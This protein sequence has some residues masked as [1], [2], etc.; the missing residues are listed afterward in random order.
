ML[1]TKGEILQI[2]GPPK[3]IKYKVKEAQ[4]TEDIIK[5]IINTHDFFRGDYDKFSGLF[6]GDS[7]YE[8]LEDIF[9][10]CRENL[11]YKVETG[12]YQTTKG[13]AVI[14][15]S[16]YN[17]C[18]HYSLFIG[19]I[20]D[21]LN[22]RHGKN[23]DW[24]YRFAG[25]ND[26]SE[27]LHHVFIVVNPGKNS[28]IW[29]D[30]CFANLDDRSSIP[31]AIDDIKVR[32]TKKHQKVKALGALE[33]I[34]LVELTD[35]LN[36]KDAI[37]ILDNITDTGGDY[38]QTVSPPAKRYLTDEE[39]NALDVSVSEKQSIRLGIEFQK[40][41][42]QYY[43]DI[44]EYFGRPVN[45][46]VLKN[47][48]FIYVLNG[49]RYELPPVTAYWG[50]PC[51]PPPEGLTVIYNRNIY[52]Y[53]IPEG[54][55]APII[56]NGKLVFDRLYF[57]GTNEE[58]TKKLMGE[59]GAFLMVIM[60]AAMGGLQLAYSSY[61]DAM[62]FE[63]ML[64]FRVRHNRNHENFLKAHNREPKTFVG[65]IIKAIGQGIESIGQGAVKIFGSVPRQAFRA[66][67]ASN[68]ANLAVYL[69]QAIN[70]D[71]NKIKKWWEKWGGD[72]DML[73]RS[74][75]AGKDEKP[76]YLGISQLKALEALSQNK[77]A[78]WDKLDI[79]ED[80]GAIGEAVSTATALTALPI[81]ASVVE[82]ISAFVKDDNTRRILQT[83]ARVMDRLGEGETPIDISKIAG[84]LDSN[85]FADINGNN[86]SNGQPP[87]PGGE[88]VYI[89]EG[90]KEKTF[91]ENKTVLI[92]LAAA[93]GLLIVMN[94]KK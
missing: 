39:I 23:I 45:Y 74:V 9:I 89:T 58:G 55:P 13:P 40:T 69:E 10:F 34:G 17:D 21:S 33:R 44:M 80:G 8:T 85:Y 88:G 66:V 6:L 38:G 72:F 61:P 2:V 79:D 30:P 20:L 28:E 75:N 65:K 32:V 57:P 48:P 29:V 25:Y 50:Q 18:K 5:E 76:Y 7:L 83:S 27:P 37:D 78:D 56:R 82:I 60:A 31:V 94:N 15:T 87:Y 3:G 16:K 90:G 43:V 36:N 54:M 41:G 68:F 77:A 70:E 59:N 67:V 47:P 12:E 81:I 1:P 24:V 46:D 84:W 64:N 71:E 53:D 26:F 86:G 42:L 93:G 62:D 52:G 19:G 11:P 22:R 73:K 35:D 14:L 92:A 4:G 51:P 49:E 91:F 63:N